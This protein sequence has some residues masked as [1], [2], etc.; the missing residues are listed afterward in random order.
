M[1]YLYHVRFSL[2]LASCLLSSL[3]S[4]QAPLKMSYQA[5]IRDAAGEL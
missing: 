4:A 2:L 5:V 1:K 3:I